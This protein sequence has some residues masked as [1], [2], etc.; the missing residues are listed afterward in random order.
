MR[1]RTDTKSSECDEGRQILHGLPV[2]IL[3]APGVCGNLLNR[4]EYKGR[5]SPRVGWGDMFCETPLP[6]MTLNSQLSLGSCSWMFI[7][8]ITKAETQ[9]K[10]INAVNAACRGQLCSSTIFIRWGPQKNNPCSLVQTHLWCSCTPLL[11]CSKLT[12]LHG[13]S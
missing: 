1:E 3:N 7:N 13:A 9:L 10:C 2:S 6:F 11:V 5:R 8:H 12:D 4:R